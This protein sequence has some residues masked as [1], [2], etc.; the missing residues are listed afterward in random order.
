MVGFNFKIKIMKCGLVFCL[1]H[2]LKQIEFQHV[3]QRFQFT[4][5][6]EEAKYKMSKSEH[7]GNSKPKGNKALKSKKAGEA[8]RKFRTT[9][10]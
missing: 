1:S 6:Q 8:K 7:Q 2:T 4:K 3:S 5:L 10:R 9:K